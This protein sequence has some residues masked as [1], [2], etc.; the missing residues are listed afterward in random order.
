MCAATAATI[1]Q[2][3]PRHSTFHS[4][5]QHVSRLLAS[6][7]VYNATGAFTDSFSFFL[8]LSLPP[9]MLNASGLVKPSWLEEEPDSAHGDYGVKVTSGTEI[10]VEK[11]T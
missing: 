11:H 7:C 8:L 3:F 5:L 6:S 4:S 1:C 10:D 9:S 2:F